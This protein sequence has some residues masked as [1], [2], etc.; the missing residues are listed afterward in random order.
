MTIT[1]KLKVLLPCTGNS[2]RSHM[3]E[4]SAIKVFTRYLPIKSTS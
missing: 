4:E 1:I 3:A 2:G